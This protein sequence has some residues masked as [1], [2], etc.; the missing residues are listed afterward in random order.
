[1]HFI[2]RILRY[3]SNKI[4]ISKDLDTILSHIFILCFLVLLLVKPQVW[5]ILV[6]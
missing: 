4:L 3:V 5:I 6:G 1:M 2:H